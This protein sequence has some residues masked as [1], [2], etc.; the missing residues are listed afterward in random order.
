MFFI[1]RI[2]PANPGPTNNGGGFCCGAA[3]EFEAARQSNGLRP[4]VKYPDKNFYS[5]E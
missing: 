2:V 3:H 5:N 1:A 4:G